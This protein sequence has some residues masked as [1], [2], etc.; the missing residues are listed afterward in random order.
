ME[1][2]LEDLFQLQTKIYFIPKTLITEA[3]P[4]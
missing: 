1:F 3:V 4:W 2:G